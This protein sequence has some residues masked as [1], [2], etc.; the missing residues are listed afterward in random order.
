MK[1]QPYFVAYARAHGRTPEAQMEV[2]RAEWRGGCM[3]GFILWIASARA[4]FRQLHPQ[5]CMPNGDIIDDGAWS[6]YLNSLS[7]PHAS[8]KR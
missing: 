6:A 1:F 4:R 7:P 3:V 5:A 2:D 8:A